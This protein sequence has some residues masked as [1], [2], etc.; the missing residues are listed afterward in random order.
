MRGPLR[1]RHG[2]H[3]RRRACRAMAS[4]ERANEQAPTRSMSR[5][6]CHFAVGSEAQP[7]TRPRQGR[8]HQRRRGR[9]CCWC[10][11][12]IGTRADR[13]RRHS[14]P[15]RSW[16]AL[17]VGVTLMQSPKVA[18][19]WERAVVLR[20]GRYV[21][22]RGPGTLLDHAVRRHGHAVDRSARDHHEL[23]RRRDAD[24]RHRAGERRRRPLLDGLRPGE[25]GARSA[26][27]PAGGELGGADGAARHH[28]PHVARPICCADASGSK[29]SCRS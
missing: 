20:L 18:K 28:R 21:G 25:G 24:V 27:L 14:A 10:R 17:I 4:A 8:A 22:L 6:C 9:C 15:G 13:R 2:L 5:G 11:S 7:G 23:R 26:G 16:S 1:E 19:Q 12:A 3:V 29:R